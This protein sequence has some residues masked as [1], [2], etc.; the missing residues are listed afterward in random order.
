MRLAVP[1]ERGHFA[2]M[3]Q[4][5]SIDTL[6]DAH[7]WWARR[8]RAMAVRTG[9]VKVTVWSTLHWVTVRSTKSANTYL[10]EP[11]QGEAFD[12]VAETQEQFDDKLGKVLR[13]RFPNER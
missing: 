5:N 7:V 8:E 11:E 9:K 6:I 10:V 13:A 4:R 2:R 12:I 1:T 3:H